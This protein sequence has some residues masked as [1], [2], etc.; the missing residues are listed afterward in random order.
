MMKMMVEEMVAKEHFPKGPRMAFINSQTCSVCV[1][2]GPHTF[3]APL[4][5]PHKGLHITNV[6]CYNNHCYNDE[7]LKICSS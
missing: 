3:I 1:C 4:C 6:F 2:A 7:C 5:G